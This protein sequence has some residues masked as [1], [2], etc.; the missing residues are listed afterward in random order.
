T[1]FSSGVIAIV[2]GLPL[3]MVIRRR[4]EDYGETVDGLPP[5]RYV[6]GAAAPVDPRRDFTAPE[7]VRTSAFWLLSL[8]H[9]FALLVVH[10]VS[11]HS[12]THMNQGLGYSIERASLVY[13]LLT[14]SQMGGVGIGW[15]IGDRYDKRLIAAICMLMHMTGLLLLTYAVSVPMVLAFAVL[16]GSAWRLRG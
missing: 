14:F 3:A 7:A 15:L 5:K 10:A 6:E 8:G 9:G 13:T 2:A 12:I 16:H 4:P 1:A 11:V